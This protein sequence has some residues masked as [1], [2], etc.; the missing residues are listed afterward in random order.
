MRSSG[1]SIRLAFAYALLCVGLWA[2]GGANISKDVQ[3]TSQKAD[4][5]KKQAEELVK[6]TTK[7]AEK[8]ALELK[9]QAETI[10]KGLVQKADSE[11]KRLE[12]KG[13]KA[14]EDVDDVF[15]TVK[16]FLD[17]S[18]VQILTDTTGVSQSVRNFLTFFNTYYNGQRLTLQA[19]DEFIFQDEKKRLRPRTVVIDQHTLQDDALQLDSLPPFLE[20]FVIPPAKLQPVRDKVDSVLLKGSKIIARYGKSNYVDGALFLMAKAFFYKSEWF[21]SQIKC[22]ELITNYPYSRFSP[23]AHLL[24]AK[25][26]LLQRKYPQGEVALSRAIDIAWGQKRYD[27][28]SEA[29]KLQADFA[30][31][32]NRLDEAVKPYRRAIAQADDPVA[33]ARWQVDLG[34]LHY[35][36]HQY[37]VAE[38]E[39]RA[40]SQLTAA[41]PLT[42]FEAL[43]FRAAVLTRLKRF[44]MA[45]TI[46][47][48]LEKKRSYDEW[49]PSYWGERLTLFRLAGNNVHL[50]SLGIVSDSVQS[51]RDPL[52]AAHY[53]RA[54]QL[55]S[56]GNDKQA[57]QLF[58]KS[59]LASAPNYRIS[60][61]YLELLRQ[62]AD[63][64]SAFA[65]V[66]TFR[67]ADSISL[68]AKS[69][70][71]LRA[72]LDTAA[73]DSLVMIFRRR[74]SAKSAVA[75]RLFAVGRTNELVT[76]SEAALQCYRAAV[77][78]TPIRDTARARYLYAEARLTGWD[79]K[80]S[81]TQRKKSDS[82]LAEIARLYPRTQHALDARTRLGVDDMIIMDS[83]ATLFASAD[84]LRSAGQFLRA[85]QE[86]ASIAARFPR[87]AYAPRSLYV[88]GNVSEQQQQRDTALTYYKRLVERYPSSR[89]AQE[90]RDMVDFAST[91]WQREQ[92]R[93]DSIRFVDSLAQVA[94]EDSIRITREVMQEIQRE[95]QKH[96][97]EKA[98]DKNNKTAAGSAQGG[99][100][101]G[102]L[103]GNSQGNPQESSQGNPQG[104]PQGDSQPSSIAAPTP[105]DTNAARGVSTQKAS[106]DSTATQSPPQRRKLKKN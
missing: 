91:Y 74:D 42:V 77:A 95:K 4:S 28:L 103:Q 47:M 98:T 6:K 21:P 105:S 90:V 1:F 11:V 40:A 18:K 104:N 44:G 96:E 68:A 70:D 48:G 76:R 59:K 13:Q 78:L 55:F 100:A 14:L 32:F 54:V 31:Y 34:V 41:D 102:S 66:E 89:Y 52:A 46:L 93:K 20:A 71:S 86:L 106:I 33:Q 87:S 88:A 45:D 67:K 82:L 72:L 61:R 27:V 26:L 99:T 9:D 84:K 17:P 2:C 53:G 8:R 65:A 85:R 23:D 56:E 101:Q 22:E 75:S 63:A 51:Y 57:E 7:D 3:A 94:R 80:A 15:M 10:G 58:Q 25:A 24:L 50:D 43:L 97:M 16:R 62:L 79:G 64:P 92:A 29:F 83:A 35:R 69:R 81:P 19:E 60:V 39:L 37:E 12:K 73:R 30:L 38:R 36:L 49:R 5:L